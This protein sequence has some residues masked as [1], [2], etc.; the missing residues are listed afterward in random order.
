MTFTAYALSGQAAGLH[1]APEE[2]PWA[3]GTDALSANPAWRR[4]NGTGWEL[5]CPQAFEATWNGGPDAADIEIRLEGVP[6]QRP[7]FVQ[8]QIG[9]GIL[10]FHTGY[11]IKTAAGQLLWVRA[12][13]NAPRDGL[14]AL[15]ST[16]DASL[17]PCTVL[18]HW[19]FT[20]PH[21]AVRFAEGEPFCTILPLGR[22][23]AWR[24]RRQQ[25]SR[26]DD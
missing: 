5:R 16:V 21:T 24:R 25:R 13:I 8:S 14:Y 17:L 1:V 20:R 15:E 18:A 3:T 11:Q 10:T 2:R 9:A 12:P 4:A 23:A 19:Q 6:D 7:S 22:L 26:A